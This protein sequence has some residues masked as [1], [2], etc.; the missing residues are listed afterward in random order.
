MFPVVAITRAQAMLVVFGNPRILSL[1]INWRG[2]MNYV[3][4]KGGWRG[5]PITW[6]P[7]EELDPGPEGYDGK[8]SQLAAEQAKVLLQ[9]LRSTIAQDEEGGV[10]VD[11]S[12]DDSDESVDDAPAVFREDE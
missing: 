9:Q 12:D 8:M 10:E 6:D 4:N 3:H 5:V 2:F 11:L 1:D 7:K